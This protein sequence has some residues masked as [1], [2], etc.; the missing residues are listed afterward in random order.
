MK[1]IGWSPTRMLMNEWNEEMK[2][3]GGI[4]NPEENEDAD[5]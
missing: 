4:T 3:W 2:E 1:R 5:E